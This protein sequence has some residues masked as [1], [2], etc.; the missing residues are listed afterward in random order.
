MTGNGSFT[1]TGPTMI[2]LTDI[3]CTDVPRGRNS[4][5]RESWLLRMTGAA[6]VRE[7]W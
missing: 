7:L 6:A 4:G 1:S 2:V 3:R 5:C